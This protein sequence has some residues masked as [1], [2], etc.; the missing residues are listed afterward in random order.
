MP[1]MAA[2]VLVEALGNDGKA[3]PVL[4]TTSQ[5]GKTADLL[6]EK[7]GAAGYLSKPLDHDEVAS[8]IGGYLTEGARP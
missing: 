3:I 7:L 2:K 8:R 6:V 4:V 5:S 1:T